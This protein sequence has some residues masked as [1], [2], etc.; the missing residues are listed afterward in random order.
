[1][2]VMKLFSYESHLCYWLA[3]AVGAVELWSLTLKVWIEKYVSTLLKCAYA[4][5]GLIGT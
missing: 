3:V 1:M 4:F 5:F 2:L